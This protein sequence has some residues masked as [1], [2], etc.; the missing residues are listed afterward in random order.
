MPT[1]LDVAAYVL[2]RRG[3]MKAAKLHVLVYYSQAWCLAW[4]GAPLFIEPIE[5]WR[6]HPVE[7]I[8]L[9]SHKVWSEVM[10]VP[11]GDAKALN[12]AQMDTVDNVLG[13]YADRSL[14]ELIEIVSRER[15]WNEV[16]PRVPFQSPRIISQE[17]M[18][19][20]YSTLR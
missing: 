8:L 5:A 15:P 4:T 1:V 3:P 17:A 13:F 9:E 18:K 16:R 11:G 12:S 2:K 14:G 7:P 10:D 20:Y 19:A 6:E